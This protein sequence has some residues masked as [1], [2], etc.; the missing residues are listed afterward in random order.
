MY[1]LDQ[2]SFDHKQVI[3]KP[4]YPTKTLIVVL[5]GMLVNF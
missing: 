1:S 5:F 4:F 3:A 2:A